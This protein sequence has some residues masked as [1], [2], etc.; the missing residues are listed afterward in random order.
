M[1]TAASSTAR[2]ARLA[3]V[4]LGFTALVTQVLVVRELLHLSG[5]NELVLGLALP[6]ALKPFQ[7]A[8]M[9]LAILMGWVMTRLILFVLF[10]LVFTPVGL[11]ARLFG[12]KFF[13]TSFDTSADSY[14]ITR[15]RVVTETSDYEKQY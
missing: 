3:L 15:E 4:C 9:T 2:F 10:Y 11:I 12:K 8:W 5:G 14:W 6:M 7:L 1:P 13:P